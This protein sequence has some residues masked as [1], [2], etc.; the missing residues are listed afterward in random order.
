MRVGSHEG[1]RN[2]ESRRC[3]RVLCGCA[4]AVG[5]RERDAEKSAASTAR[6]LRTVLGWDYFRLLALAQ[7]RETGTGGGGG[8]RETRGRKH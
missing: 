5:E 4:M 1:R 2:R 7:V 8:R 3:D 6:L